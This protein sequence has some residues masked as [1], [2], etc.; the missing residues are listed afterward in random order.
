MM[1]GFG[2]MLSMML[3][4]F[5]PP[6][7]AFC[8]K[9]VPSGMDGVT[10]GIL[11]GLVKPGDTP[12]QIRVNIA[13]AKEYAKEVERQWKQAADES[14]AAE[15]IKAAEYR[16]KDAESAVTDIEKKIEDLIAAVAEQRSIVEQMRINI[17]NPKTK[18]G[19]EAVQS[20]RELESRLASLQ[21]HKTMRLGS[22]E[23]YKVR[24]AKALK[25]LDALTAPAVKAEELKPVSVESGDINDKA[26]V[27]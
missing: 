23:E 16:L 25:A 11:S 27:Q 3:G 13:T 10:L 2:M 21:E 17:E 12:E 26:S 1:G 22:V 15:D 18:T 14:E 20:L 24:H 4:P 7:W 5:G 8:G 9:K 6:A 19:K